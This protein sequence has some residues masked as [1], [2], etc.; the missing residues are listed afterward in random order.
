[1][2]FSFKIL[3]HII[4]QKGNK[5]EIPQAKA[6]GMTKNCLRNDTTSHFDER[7][8]EK[9]PYFEGATNRPLNTPPKQRRFLAFGFGM[10]RKNWLRNDTTSHFERS[11][12]SPYFE[13]APNRPL[14]TPPNNNFALG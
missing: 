1:M 5:E 11:E 14:N 8:E 3:S 10:T 4:I 9:S 6:F 12:K 13:G 2:I 7:S